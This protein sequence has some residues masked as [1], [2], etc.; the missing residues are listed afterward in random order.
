MAWSA[1]D[2]VFRLCR[3]PTEVK[4]EE[5]KEDALDGWLVK[6]FR[7]RDSDNNI[8]QKFYLN[9]ALSVRVTFVTKIRKER[10]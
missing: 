7:I 6:S 3:R 10:I 4:E 2:H 9:I 5:H 8:I 1:P